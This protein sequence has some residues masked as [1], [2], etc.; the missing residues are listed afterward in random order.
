MLELIERDGLPEVFAAGFSM[1]GNLV[2]KMAGEFGE[3]RAG[4]AAWIRAVAPS[5]DLASCASRPRS[6]RTFFTSGISFAV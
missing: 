6:R 1:G 5:M 4:G 2:L 3:F